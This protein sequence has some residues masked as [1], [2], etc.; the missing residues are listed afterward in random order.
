MIHYIKTKFWLLGDRRDT[1][2][3]EVFENVGRL[4]ASIYDVWYDGVEPH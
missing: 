2:T 3:V 1:N 4:H